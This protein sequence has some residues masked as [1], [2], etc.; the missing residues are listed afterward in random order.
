M[1]LRLRFNFVLT[2][3]FLF[4]ILVSGFISYDL[5]HKNA[6]D[7]VIRNADLMIEMARAVRSYTVNEVRPKL[8]PQ[9]KEVFHPQTV[10]A[11]AATSTL[12]RLAKTYKDY[13]YREA[14]LNPTNP[15]DRAAPWEA[16]LV[17]SFKRNRSVKNLIGERNTSAGR[18]LYIARPLRIGNKACLTCHS[19]PAIAPASLIAKY[20]SN[21]GFGWKLNEIVG[22]QVV[23]VPMSVPIA[24]ANEAFFTFMVSLCGLFLLLYLV[25]NYMLTKII[26]KPVTDM[27]HAADEISTG[28]FGISEFESERKD[29]IGRLGLS[30]NRMRR[31]LERAMK[32]MDA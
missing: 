23:S 16:K 32:L 18:S 9:L 27:S 25:L 29:E 30:F 11:Y 4:G 20:G 1:G 3:L 6:R 28:N 24:K 19:A 31:S 12:D 8:A 5:L 21:N 7:E 26:I 10:P 14:T 22:A 15:R 17:D 13:S 2:T